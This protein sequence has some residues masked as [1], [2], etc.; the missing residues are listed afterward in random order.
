MFQC[1]QS[2]SHNQRLALSENLLN[3]FHPM[4][5]WPPQACGNPS[6]P[7][8][9]PFTHRKTKTRPTSEEPVSNK[10]PTKMAKVSSYSQTFW[11]SRCQPGHKNFF[12]HPKKKKKR[13]FQH[14]QRLGRSAEYDVQGFWGYPYINHPSSGVAVSFQEASGGLDISQVVAHSNRLGMAIGIP[15]LG[16]L[17]TC[18]RKFP[19]NKTKNINTNNSNKNNHDNHNSHSNSNSQ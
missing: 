14:W 7:M 12:K 10:R 18:T 4:V 15:S 1:S 5:P 2:L 13:L 8:K 9:W 3:L 6:W 11:G 17:S 19:P 16:N